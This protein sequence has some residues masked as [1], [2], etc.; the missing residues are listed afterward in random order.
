M[1]KKILV[2]VPQG[3]Y[4]HIQSLKGQF[5]D[6][7]S[8][9]VRNIV[10]SYLSEQGYFSKYGIIRSSPSFKSNITEQRE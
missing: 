8:A 9:V 6:S 4:K 3:V 5:G 10:I 2:S 7:D 1:M